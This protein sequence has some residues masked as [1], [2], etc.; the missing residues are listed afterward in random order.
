MNASCNSLAWG[1]VSIEGMISKAIR[2]DNKLQMP[3]TRESLNRLFEKLN[4]YVPSFKVLD[5]LVHCRGKKMEEA[6]PEEFQ[7]KRL[8]HWFELNLRAL[9]HLDERKV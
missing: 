5:C 9:K 7:M 3:P 6:P 2:E 1:A 8:V 4:L